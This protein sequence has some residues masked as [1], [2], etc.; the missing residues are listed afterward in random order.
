M[1]DYLGS[2]ES[3]LIV[4]SVVYLEDEGMFYGHTNPPKK[5]RFRGNFAV[6]L[7][8]SREI[9]GTPNSGTPHSHTAP[10]RV[11]GSMGMAREWY[12][13]LMGRGVPLLVVPGEIFRKS[14]FFTRGSIE[15]V[16]F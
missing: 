4:C 15:K 16:A 13:K 3:P 5:I 12:G 1:S 9:P 7:R 8:L 6:P 11:P 10:I 2:L 14:G